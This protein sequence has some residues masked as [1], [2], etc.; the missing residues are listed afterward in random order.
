MCTFAFEI[1]RPV[2]RLGRGR[3]ALLSVIRVRAGE[4]D[5]LI[6]AEHRQLGITDQVLVVD[7]GRRARMV[8]HLLM[9]TARSARM[10]AVHRSAL[11]PMPPAL[12]SARFVPG[13]RRQ[14][15]RH[16]RRLYVHVR[17][18]PVKQRVVVERKPVDV[19]VPDCATVSMS[20]LPNAITEKLD[21]PFT[22]VLAALGSDVDARPG[23]PSTRQHE[24]PCRSF[25][26][27]GSRC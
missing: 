6:S 27:A 16:V 5:V 7:V 25:P 11:K 10:P 21:A 1:E 15:E 20:S 18:Q 24:Q 26:S 23:S 12:I 2:E 22:A 17:D 13:P 19:A 14:L 9:S 8:S 4:R 3:D